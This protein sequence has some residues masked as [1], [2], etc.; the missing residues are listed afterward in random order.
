MYLVHVILPDRTGKC[1]TVCTR[2][3]SRR[4][5]TAPYNCRIISRITAEPH[6]LAG[7][8][9]TGLAGRDLSAVQL[10]R[11]C[12]TIALIKYSLKDIRHHPGCSLR[13]YLCLFLGILI[14]H[15]IG[16]VT[17]LPDTGTVAVLTVIGKCRIPLCHIHNPDTL[18]K[19][20]ER[21]CHITVVHITEIMKMHLIQKG[22]TIFRRDHFK[23]LPCDR[24]DGTRHRLTDMHASTISSAGVLWSVADRMI[25]Y[26]R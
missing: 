6:I 19:P 16:N 8:R 24:I 22:K 14:D 3:C 5:I 15:T 13:V 18:G 12:C 11:T 17:D 23:H 1:G 7:V 2:H 10:Q 25:V 20:T 26:Y 9:G 21:Q 4:I